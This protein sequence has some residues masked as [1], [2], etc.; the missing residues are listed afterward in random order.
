MTILPVSELK[1][2]EK[3]LNLVSYGNE[4]VL[5]ENGALKYAIVDIKEL[6]DLRGKIIKH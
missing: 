5:T 4:V 6:E 1:D 2:Y 3:V